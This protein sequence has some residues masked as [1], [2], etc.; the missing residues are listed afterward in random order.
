MKLTLKNSSQQLK[1]YHYIEHTLS[2]QLDDFEA[3]KIMG[4]LTHQ[5]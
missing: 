1:N 3:P 5:K 4:I 2:H